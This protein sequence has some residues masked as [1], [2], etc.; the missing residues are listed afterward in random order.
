MTTIFANP[1]G[2]MLFAKMLPKKPLAKTP[3]PPPP[4]KVYRVVSLLERPNTTFKNVVVTVNGGHT[5]DADG[6][7]LARTHIP[8]HIPLPQG[9]CVCTT[10]NYD[11]ADHVGADPS[12]HHLHVFDE[13]L[14]L[15]I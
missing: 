12:R 7:D 5:I 1:D 10:Y 2:T 11:I 15:F 14:L 3:P 8:A 9:L 13:I 6:Y 4:K